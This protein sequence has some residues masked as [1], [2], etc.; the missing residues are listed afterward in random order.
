[1]KYS[2]HLPPLG[3]PLRQE[4][5]ELGR[6]LAEKQLVVVGGTGFLGKVWLS[7]VL[8]KFPQVGHIYLVVRPKAGMGV[9]ERFKKK[10]LTSEVFH[11]LRT[12]HG[13]QFEQFIQQRVTPIA[14]DVSEVLCGLSG[15]LRDQIR[16]KIAA[17]VNVAGVVDF[18][19]PLDEALKVNAFGC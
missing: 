9:L 3:Q 8:Y 15:P 14:G 19:P 18:S 1:M 16:G 5:L 17:V 2:T 10:V 7:L 13:E 6:L 12:L 11:P 4:P